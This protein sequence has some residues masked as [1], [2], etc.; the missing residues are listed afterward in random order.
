MSIF[1]NEFR[2]VY[3]VLILSFVELFSYYSEIKGVR[4]ELSA[5]MILT[6]YT[7]LIIR[8]AF[9]KYSSNSFYFVCVIM[10]V[11]ILSSLYSFLEFKNLMWVASFL[12]F[13]CYLMFYYIVMHYAN[14]DATRLLWGALILCSIII[15]LSFIGGWYIDN[16]TF[17]N[18][19]LRFR[20][21]SHTSSVLGCFSGLLALVTFNITFVGKMYTGKKRCFVFLLFVLSFAM[22][23]LTASRQPFYGVFCAIFLAWSSTYF[24]HKV[25]FHFRVSLVIIFF[26]AVIL[27]L[28]FYIDSLFNIYYKMNSFD[29]S[30]S[31]RL[32]YLKVGLIHLYE[33]NMLLF[34]N[35]MNSFPTIYDDLTGLEKPAAHNIIL[36]LLFNFGIV[37]LFIFLGVLSRFYIRVRGDVH[38]TSL[39]WYLLIG[40]SLNNPEYFMSV[41]LM[42]ILLSVSFLQL[43]NKVC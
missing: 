43:K 9:L 37:G 40:L 6:I 29:S 36:M 27:M 1:K 28:P 33:S 18:D 26:L 20:G 16:V 11:F 17:L 23:Y 4:A 5:L 34:G 3:F 41:S 39:F 42:L 21:L 10:M 14:K 8:F 15:L 25:N 22:T 32:K 19:R 31:G 24:Y 35:G 2:F 30:F 12:K 7:L 38:L 13:S